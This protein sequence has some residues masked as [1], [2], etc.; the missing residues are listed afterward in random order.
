[1]PS[2]RSRG[3][4]GKTP[5]GAEAAA[6]SDGNFLTVQ[7]EGE[8]AD[9][10][11]T[12]QQANMENVAPKDLMDSEILRLRASVTASRKLLDDINSEVVE[13]VEIV[14]EAKGRN[15]PKA[16]LVQYPKF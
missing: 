10:E 3:G 14:T 5:A 13:Q 6:G 15:R 16:V 2:T 4:A 11:L 1:M 12:T 8:S 9:I 7:P